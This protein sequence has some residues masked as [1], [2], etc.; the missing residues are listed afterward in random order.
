MSEQP[1]SDRRH[2]K[3][4]MSRRIAVLPIGHLP[5]RLDF[6]PVH[7]TDRFDTFRIGDIATMFDAVATSK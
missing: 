3:S 2:S 5:V 6:G 7:R 1:L 4:K